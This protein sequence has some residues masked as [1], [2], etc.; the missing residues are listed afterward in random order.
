MVVRVHPI[1][2]VHGGNRLGRN[3]AVLL[4]SDGLA[5]RYSG[6]QTAAYSWDAALQRWD[7]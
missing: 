4:R 3:S 1:M 2:G 5:R 6:D 7:V